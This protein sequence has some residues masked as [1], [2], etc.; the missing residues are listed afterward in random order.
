[1][2]TAKILSITGIAVMV[3]A[4]LYG[5]I[6]GDFSAWLTS[7]QMRPWTQ[8]LMVDV[9]VGF[10]LFSGWI[11]FREASKGQAVVWIVLLL[12]LGNLVSCIYVWRSFTTCNG[13]WRRF[14]M[15]SH[16]DGQER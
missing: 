9:Y 16:A 6:A 5:F 4:I 8:V 15:G 7:L 13:D 2:E 11:Y 1:M 12:L 3:I 14:W 10:F